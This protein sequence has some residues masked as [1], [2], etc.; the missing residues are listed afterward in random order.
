[1]G[2]KEVILVGTDGST[3]FLAAVK[4]ASDRAVRTGARVHVICTYALAS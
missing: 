1:M 3:E 2:S 4:W